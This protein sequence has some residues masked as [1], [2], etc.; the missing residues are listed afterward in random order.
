MSPS[1]EIAI[2]KANR[3]ISKKKEALLINQ[4]NNALSIIHETE[5]HK[6]LDFLKDKGVHLTCINDMPNKDDRVK[7]YYIKKDTVID[8][9]VHEF[10]ESYIC[11]F[12]KMKINFLN[13]STIINS[14]ETF[15]VK[16]YTTHSIEF[17]EDTFLVVFAQ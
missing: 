5:Y 2:D 13:S 17:L 12:G 8:N 14:F 3:L 9:H 10:N 11:L 1:F 16:K 7:V 15:K 6:I 4:I